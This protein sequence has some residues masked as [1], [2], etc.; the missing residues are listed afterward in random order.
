MAAK[1]SARAVFAGS[2]TRKC[3][4]KELSVFPGHQRPALNSRIP[5]AVTAR[6]LWSVKGHLPQ[7]AAGCTPFAERSEPVEVWQQSP[8]LP[9]PLP[10]LNGYR[11]VAE[12]AICQHTTC[13]W[14]NYDAVGCTWVGV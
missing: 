1:T 4:T 5:A 14:L 12:T 3:G 11:G 10:P 13:G 2:Y 7:R 6:V 8:A 9:T